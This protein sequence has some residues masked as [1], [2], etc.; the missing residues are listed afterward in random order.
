MVGKDYPGTW[1][2]FQRWFP[3]DEAC[4]KYLAKLRWPEGF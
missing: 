3:D 4:A 2:Q 1:P